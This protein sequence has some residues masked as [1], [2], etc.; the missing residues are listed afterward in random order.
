[1]IS[2]RRSFTKATTCASEL[3]AGNSK[4][5]YIVN[6]SNNVPKLGELFLKVLMQ[7][8]LEDINIS[9]YN[10]DDLPIQSISCF[11]MTKERYFIGTCTASQNL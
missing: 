5:S 1:M 2:S 9:F 6:E 10:L 8:K 7:P 4:F 11:Q 3:K